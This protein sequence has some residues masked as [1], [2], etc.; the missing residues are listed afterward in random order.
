MI[1]ISQN[2]S[3]AG[4]Y[5]KRSALLNNYCATINSSVNTKLSK[6][7]LSHINVNDKHKFLFCRIPKIGT[8][9]W[10]RVLLYLMSDE[11]DLEVFSIKS[12]LIHQN[13]IYAKKIQATALTRYSKKQIDFRLKT[14]QKI[15][16]V[17]H[18]LDRLFSAYRNKLTTSTEENK[19][20][21]FQWYGTKIIR[22]Y[23]EN[24]T[25]ES[26][27]H[28]NDVKFEEFLRYVAETSKLD[29]HWDTYSNLCAPC[30]VHYDFI[31]KYETMMEDANFLLDDWGV[32]Q[33]RF[34]QSYRTLEKESLAFQKAIRSVPLQT[35][36]KIRQRYDD[37]FK[38]FNY[39]RYP[40]FAGE[41]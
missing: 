32:N 23:R 22:Q 33:I 28:G 29:E 2:A 8:T 19:A 26:L 14:Y 37:D 34:P 15:I 21:F 10:K 9:N 4:R 7:V 5:T 39:D 17:R 30:Q 38:T 1:C 25:N 40:L 13:S 3:V 11:K 27:A 12:N 6:V 35:L 36:D 24:A 31:G 41:A 16:F 20:T 18:P